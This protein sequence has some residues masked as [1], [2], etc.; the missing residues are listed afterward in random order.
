MRYAHGNIVGYLSGIPGTRYV[1]VLYVFSVDPISC[2]DVDP[3]STHPLSTYS[4]RGSTYRSFTVSSPYGT[5][6]RTDV[7]SVT[8]YIALIMS[9]HL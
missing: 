7:G 8:W 9:A 3:G 1:R 6:R 4:R 2:T 5:V